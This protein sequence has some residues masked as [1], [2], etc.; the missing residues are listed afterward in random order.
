MEGVTGGLPGV[1][2]GM[3]GPGALAGELDSLLTHKSARDRAKTEKCALLH[4]QSQKVLARSMCAMML[5]LVLFLFLFLFL[6]I[7]SPVHSRGFSHV[8]LSFFIFL[9]MYGIQKVAL[10]WRMLTWAWWNP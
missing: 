6:L 9:P 1:P 2:P 8:F 7:Q 10:M 3:G 5:Y 4:A